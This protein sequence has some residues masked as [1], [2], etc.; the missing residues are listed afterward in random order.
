MSIDERK[1]LD[2]IYAFISDQTPNFLS[3]LSTEYPKP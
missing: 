1:F 2:K 3:S